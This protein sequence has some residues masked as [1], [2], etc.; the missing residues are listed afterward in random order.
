MAKK[1]SPPQEVDCHSNVVQERVEQAMVEIKERL[2]SLEKRGRPESVV[3]SGM[4]TLVPASMT[5]QESA[6]S[7]SI[8]SERTWLYGRYD[9]LKAVASH[10]TPGPEKLLKAMETRDLSKFINLLETGA[11]DPNVIVDKYCPTPALVRACEDGRAE[12]AEALLKYG[13]NPSS[14][15]SVDQIPL[16]VAAG[17][18][19]TDIVQLLVQHGANVNTQVGGMIVT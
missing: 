19:H 3:E 9:N 1:L 5:R 11:V 6:T 2:V 16:L 8:E 10:L 13:A 12:F 17:N 14:G 7:F 4:H 18:G 15:G